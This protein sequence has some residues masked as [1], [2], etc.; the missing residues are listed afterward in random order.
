MILSSTWRTLVNQLKLS[1]AEDRVFRSLG[2][3][4]NLMCIISAYVHSTSHG[5]CTFTN[6]SLSSK[7]YIGRIKT[8]ARKPNQLFF[9]ILKQ[10]FLRLLVVKIHMCK[11]THTH[12]LTGKSEDIIKIDYILQTT[13]SF[14]FEDNF[15]VRITEKIKSLLFFHKVTNI[16]DEENMLIFS[17]N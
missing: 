2:F 8:Q 5:A 17:S 6:T 9:T 13:M 1:K 3:R 16:L 7:S 12:T 4:G 10:I 15:L 11:H 14:C